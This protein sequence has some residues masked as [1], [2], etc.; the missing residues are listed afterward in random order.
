[1]Q[2]IQINKKIQLKKVQTKNVQIQNEIFG[3]FKKYSI[4]KMFKSENVQACKKN[5]KIKKSV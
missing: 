4:K 3:N 1:L 5:L 2:N